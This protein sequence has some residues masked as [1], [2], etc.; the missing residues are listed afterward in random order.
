MDPSAHASDSSGIASM[1]FTNEAFE[2]APLSVTG[3]SA[4]DSTEGNST[5]DAQVRI[6]T[7]SSS[8]SEANVVDTKL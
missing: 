4:G 6:S 1:V 2:D 7:S 8:D 3:E 5:A